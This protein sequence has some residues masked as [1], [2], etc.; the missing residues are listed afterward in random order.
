MCVLAVAWCA[1]PRW[2]LVVAGNRDELHA[3]PA[4][5]LA[6]WDTSSHLIA[7]KDLQAGGT[8]LGVSEQGR[9][10]VITNLRGF[11]PPHAGRPSRGLLLQG[12]LLGEGQYACPSDIELMDFNPFNLISVDLR[13][14][15]FLSNRPTALRQA[16]APGVYG[17]SNGA[18]DEPWPKTVRLKSMLLD[19]V[20]ASAQRPELL[21]NNLREDI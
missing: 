17:L 15:T 21:L 14:A 4:Q 6:R 16:L 2:R 8:W 9:F 18:L 12:L 13:A 10:A 5:P 7:G 20:A 19:W 11:G 3:R 1:H